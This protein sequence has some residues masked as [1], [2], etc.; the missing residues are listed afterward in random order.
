MR[1]GNNRSFNRTSKPLSVAYIIGADLMISRTLFNQMEGF[2][3]DFFMYYEETDLCYRVK[4]LK[5]E[6]HCIPNSKIIHLE[7]GSQKKT[8]TK[9][10]LRKKLES[11][12][13]IYMNRNHGK[14]YIA[15]DSLLQTVYHGI[16]DFL[17][18]GKYK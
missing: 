10:S 11:S 6:I 8:K 12:R 16:V 17:T 18:N 1:F 13:K 14:L 5:K 9:V 3:S 7:G 4:K 2:S 15:I